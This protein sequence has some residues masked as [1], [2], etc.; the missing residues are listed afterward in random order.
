MRDVRA[1]HTGARVASY[2]GAN[3]VPVSSTVKDLSLAR[4]SPSRIAVRT[5]LL[6]SQVNGGCTEWRDANSVTCL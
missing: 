2:A 6:A 3:E 1:V 5:S 4:A